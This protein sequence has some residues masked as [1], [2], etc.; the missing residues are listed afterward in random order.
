[1]KTTELVELLT[2]VKKTGNDKWQ[3]K[4][5]AHDD[6]QASLSITTTM[7][8][9]TLLHCHAGCE[10]SAVLDALG[11]SS[12]D[13]FPDRPFEP[14]ARQKPKTR[15]PAKPSS[16]PKTPKTIVATYDY[17]DAEG[18][19]VYQSV[20]FEPKTF[21]LR[22]PDGNG[23]WIWKMEGI[24]RIPYNLPNC[25]NAIQAKKAIFIVEGEKDAQ[26]LISLGLNATSN[27]GGAEKWLPSMSELLAGADLVILPDNDDTGR[28]HAALVA[29]YSADFA[30]SIRVIELEGLPVKGDVSDWLALGHTKEELIALARAEQ[31]ILPELKACADEPSDASDD[32]DNP[33]ALLHFHKTDL[34]NAEAF[35]KAHGHNMRYCRGLSKDLFLIWSGNRWIIDERGEVQRWAAQTVRDCYK[36]LGSVRQAEQNDLFKHLKKSERADRLNAMIN[37]S[38]HVDKDIPVVSTDLDADPWVFNVQ[39]GTIDLKTGE[40]RPHN[41]KDL[42]TKIAP[43]TFDPTA[44]CGRWLQFLAEVFQNDMELITYVQRIAGYCLSGSV[45]EQL[46][47]IL[48]GKGA[49]GKSVLVE[50][51]RH[52]V[53]DYGSDT[54]VTTFTEKT[55][56]ASSVGLASLYGARMVSAAEGSGDQVWDEALLKKLTGGDP[57]TARHLYCPYFTYTPQFKLLVSSNESP[58]LRGQGYAIKRRVRI[59][60]FKVRFYDPQEDMLPVR[61]PNL[62]QTLMEELP[63]ILNWALQGCLDWQKHGLGMPKSVQEDTDKL[64]SDQDPLLEWLDECTEMVPDA[65]HSIGELYKSYKDWA[66]NN[67]RE[68]SFKTSQYFSR[69]LAQRDGIDTYRTSKARFL[70]GL[71]LKD[72]TEAV[73][74]SGLDT[75]IDEFNLIFNEDE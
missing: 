75:I 72:V 43:V 31:D 55:T 56:D 74:G 58:R 23:G 71:Q 2:G 18:Q 63:G 4:C 69:N 68:V 36:F 54:A 1:M 12:K 57:I 5:P 45:R 33:A 27:P 35:A 70:K 19:L 26:A 9:K 49:N 40:L 11:L 3:A 17:L 73:A 44:E 24:E 64:F 15:Q 34:G 16:E 41:R 14:S 30:H 20:R 29:Y 52:I 7:D 32:A 66:A 65:S 22:R 28:N 46:L 47:F 50:T 38:R 13:L 6:R 39:N 53:G 25:L 51:L 42:I 8:G 37:L 48:M 59:I 60:P 62:I 67:N 21:Q 61:D 10:T